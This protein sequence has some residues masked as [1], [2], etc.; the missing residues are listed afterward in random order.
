MVSTPL[1]QVC[2]HT[3]HSLEVQYLKSLTGASD[4][5]IPEV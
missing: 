3:A 1:L 5:V 4:A 2:Y